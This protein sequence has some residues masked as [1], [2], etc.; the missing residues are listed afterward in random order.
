MLPSKRNLK[1]RNLIAVK[2]FCSKTDYTNKYCTPKESFA[3]YKCKNGYKFENNQSNFEK[4]L[5][6]GY[7][8]K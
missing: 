7:L 1:K 3:S 5:C 8:L 4:K 6:F 2:V